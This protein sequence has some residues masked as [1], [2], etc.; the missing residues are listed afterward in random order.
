MG[1]GDSREELLTGLEGHWK[2]RR[3]LTKV[4]MAWTGPL[5]C[6]SSME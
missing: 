5:S 3:M 4:A 1:L 6:A 2:G